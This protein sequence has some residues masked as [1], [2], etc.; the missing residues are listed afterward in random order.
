MNIKLAE[1]IELDSIQMRDVYAGCIVGMIEHGEPVMVLDADL[2]RPLGI[3]PYKD[4]YPE[5]IID[6][7]IAE[8]NMI[9]VAC[10]LSAE[11]FVPFT[12]SFAAF[13]SRRVMDQ[14]FMS[15]AYARQNVKMVGSDP[16]V[17]AALNGGTHMAFEDVAMMRAVPEMTI[18]EPTDAVMLEDLL[19]KIAH[20]RG[21]VYLRLCRTETERIY[22]P[23][24]D[25]EIGRAAVL[26]EGNDLTIIASGREVPEAVRAAGLLSARGISAR[27][28][29]MFTVKP[30]DAGAVERAA[31]ETGAIVTA[32]NHNIIGG[33]GSAVA[34]LTS[35]LCPVPVERVGV[36][37]SFGV[38]GKTEYLMRRFAL[39]AEDIVNS[40]MRVLERKRTEN[41]GRDKE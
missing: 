17:C 7:G 33:L 36:R 38:V 41:S 37:D 28:L 24:S 13:A 34:E 4:K 11:G 21:M 15:G 25:F 8:A 19:P 10:G 3:L 29:D 39:T 23:G 27:V 35:E 32:E 6:C 18:I 22:A 14:V 12:H 30:L 40:A 2:M 26:R 9:G 1:K 16:G 5:N 31:V 20:S